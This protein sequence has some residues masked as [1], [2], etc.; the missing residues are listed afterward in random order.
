MAE[1]L[2]ESTMKDSSQLLSIFCEARER[3]SAE[4]RA[5][6]LDEACR[7]DAPYRVRLRRCDV[8]SRARLRHG[9][10]RPCRESAAVTVDSLHNRSQ[11]CR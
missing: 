8:G 11:A 5:A 3:L 7:D 1:Q 2:R 4:Q 6:Y 10:G 9:S